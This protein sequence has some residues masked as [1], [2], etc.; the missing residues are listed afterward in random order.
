MSR[1]RVN[2]RL[3]FDR[4]S[5]VRHPERHSRAVV[6]VIDEAVFVQIKLKQ[7]WGSVN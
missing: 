3:K 5:R 4:L 7:R 2:D 6:F 1:A